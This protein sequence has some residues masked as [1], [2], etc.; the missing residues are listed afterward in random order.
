MNQARFRMIEKLDP[1]RFNRL[2]QEA[3]RHANQR[4][5][6]YQHM[7]ALTLPQ[8]ATEPVGA[9]PAAPDKK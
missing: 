5:A 1:P 7:A 8:H 9:P 6:L 4:V 3:Q 2:A